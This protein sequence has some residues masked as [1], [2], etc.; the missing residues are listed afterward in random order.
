[1]QEELEKQTVALVFKA[2]KLT[3]E[4]LSN[5]M[6]RALE[7]GLSLP[8][9]EKEAHG[10]MTL[11][12][13]V[14]KG[15]ETKKI[16]FKEEDLKAFHKTA[17]KY[18]IDYAIHSEPEGEMTKYYVF[19]QA[20]DAAAIDSAFKEFVAKNEKHKDSVKEKLNKKKEKVRENKEKQR[21][22]IHNKNRNRE[23]R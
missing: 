12:D 11:Y 20:K 2:G 23:L 3:T 13:L 9:K 16:E 21:E 18:N 10:K 17:S 6:H 14:G 4:A 1:M 8:K 15:H 5:A 19:F 7:K 22:R